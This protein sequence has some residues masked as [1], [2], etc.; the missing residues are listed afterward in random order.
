MWVYICVFSSEMREES[1]TR[2]RDE[3]VLERGRDVMGVGRKNGI[4]NREK[5]CHV[6]TM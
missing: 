6:L 4:R 3:K 1:R 5:G 2:E